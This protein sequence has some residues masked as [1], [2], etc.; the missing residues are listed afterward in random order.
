MSAHSQ[1]AEDLALYAL[2]A[3]EGLERSELERHLEGCVACRSELQRLRGDAA[4]LALAV[5][6]VKPPAGARQR[7]M[8][9]VAA[10]PRR[11]V[12]EVKPRWRMLTPVLA[13]IAAVLA[14]AVLALWRQ[15]VDIDR[16]LAKTQR[17]MQSLTQEYG[18]LQADAQHARDVLDV[19]TSRDAVRVTLAATNAKP[20]PQGKAFYIPKSGRLVFMASNLAPIPAGKTY[21]LWLIPKNG[22]APMPA[23]VFRPDAGGSANVMM[24]SLP[25]GMEAKAF[26]ITIEPEG[27]TSTPT[28]P[29]VLAGA[30]P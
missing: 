28:M 17:E 19:I 5:E 18:Q 22:H 23:G 24:P 25:A 29:L 21:E 20:Q 9:A 16:R 3:L 15:N 6:Q 1:F 26:A 11:T 7:L 4:L 12:A 10:E 27:G 2:G 30:A 8:A 14:I 13:A